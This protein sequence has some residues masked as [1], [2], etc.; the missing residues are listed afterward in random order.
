MSPPVNACLATFSEF[1]MLNGRVIPYTLS[2]ICLSIAQLLFGLSL[3]IIP[4]H[5][6]DIFTKGLWI[7]GALLLICLQMHGLLRLIISD[8]YLTNVFMIS[9]ISSGPSL[10]L[11]RLLM[12]MISRTSLLP[13][14]HTCAPIIRAVVSFSL[15]ST[16]TATSKNCSSV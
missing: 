4:T 8:L 6:F 16:L 2:R 12:L 1:Y 15:G 11:S 7:I 9:W 3:C 14:F 13:W 5:P 10:L